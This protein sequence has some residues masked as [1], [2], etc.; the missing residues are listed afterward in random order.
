MCGDERPSGVQRRCEHSRDGALGFSSYEDRE[1][2]SR[3]KFFTLK[4]SAIMN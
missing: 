2:R 1:T 4:K 3:P